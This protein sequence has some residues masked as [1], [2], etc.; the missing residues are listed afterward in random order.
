MTLIW[1]ISWHNKP[2]WAGQVK[3]SEFEGPA[4]F[5]TPLKVRKTNIANETTVLENMLESHGTNM[6]NMSNLQ[7]LK[8]L[9]ISYFTNQ[10]VNP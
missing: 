5:Y 10:H 7:R 6:D 8:P 3:I 9:A 4:L 2:T 1:I